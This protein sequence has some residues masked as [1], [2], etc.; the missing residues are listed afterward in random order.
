V[1]MYVDEYD[2]T[3]KSEHIAF[4]R[5]CLLY[6]CIHKYNKQIRINAMCSVLTKTYDNV[7]IYTRF[8]EDSNLHI[9]E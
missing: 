8:L 2:S 9:T 5:I 3:P 1:S 6:L 7:S 4:I